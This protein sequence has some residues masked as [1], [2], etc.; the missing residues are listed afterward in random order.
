MTT[1]FLARLS[2]S[3]TETPIDESGRTLKFNRIERLKAPL[4]P[5]VRPFAKLEL[6]PTYFSKLLDYYVEGKML[7]F[8]VA[9]KF[10]AEY[11]VRKESIM[12]NVETIKFFGSTSDELCRVEATLPCTIF[13][14]KLSPVLRNQ[15][16]S[17]QRTFLMSACGNA[18]RKAR[19]MLDEEE[20]KIRDEYLTKLALLVHSEQQKKDEEY[21][22]RRMGF[23]NEHFQAR[24]DAYNPEASAIRRVDSASL[25]NEL[26]Q[27]KLNL[28]LDPVERYLQEDHWMVIGQEDLNRIV[29]KR[30]ELDIEEKK[31]SGISNL[32]EDTT[33]Q[34]LLQFEDRER[35]EDFTSIQS[36][37]V[38]VPDLPLPD[39]LLNPEERKR[40]EQLEMDE[41]L[42]T[43]KARTDLPPLKLW[44]EEMAQASMSSDSVEDKE[45]NC[46]KD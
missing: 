39:Y 2:K 19:Q 9:Q 43:K 35:D 33:E 1:K 25:A 11:S 15:P 24:L 26:Q 5:K 32:D 45:S 30:I 29:E 38:D 37:L 6:Q 41:I 4:K 44:E 21:V 36:Q 46:E 14:V 27:R 28:L 13:D 7:S 34:Y 23:D 12:R 20:N 18:L 22:A 3:L 8:D 40:L 42:K 16:K 10:I 31:N 17:V